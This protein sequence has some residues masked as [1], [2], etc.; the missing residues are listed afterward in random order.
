MTLDEYNEQVRRAADAIALAFNEAARIVQNVID[1]F[2]EFFSG[3]AT[4]FVERYAIER[5]GIT[6]ADIKRIDGW[7][8]V[9][10]NRRRIVVDPKDYKA[11][12]VGA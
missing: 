3:W 8:V 11:W 12:A 10:W 1:A 6:E 2:N 9:L 4:M 7:T 5:L